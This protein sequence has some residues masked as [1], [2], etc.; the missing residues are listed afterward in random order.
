MH[1]AGASQQFNKWI[2]TDARGSVLIARP[3]ATSPP[4]LTARSF[5]CIAGA[6]YPKRW[7]E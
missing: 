4:M 2:S 1:S 7:T 5:R 3:A 6:G